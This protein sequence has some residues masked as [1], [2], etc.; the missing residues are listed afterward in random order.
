MSVQSCAAH[1]MISARERYHVVCPDGAKCRHGMERGSQRVNSTLLGEVVGNG[2]ECFSLFEFFLV[3]EQN[4][5][6]CGD[7]SVKTADC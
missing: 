5:L 1:A 7:D 3:Q 6:G 4:K 2:R